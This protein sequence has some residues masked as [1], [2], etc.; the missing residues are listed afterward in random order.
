MMTALAVEWLK[1]RRTM[2]FWITTI[3]LGVGTPA[4]ATG[5]VELARSGTASGATEAKLSIIVDANA[6]GVHLSV[7]SQ[8][9]A[10]AA[11]LAAGVVIGWLFGREFTDHTVGAL[12]ALPIAKHTIAAAKLLLAVVWVCGVS[13]LATVL[14][15]VLAWIT[16]GRNMGT[17][18]DA[19]PVVAVGVMSGLLAIPLGWVAT[20]TR[21][22]L[23]AIGILIG[24]IVVTQIVTTVGAGTWFPYAI[25]SL[26]AGIAGPDA[27]ATIGLLQLSTVGLVAILGT[28]ATILSWRRLQIA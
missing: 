11:M 18:T 17:I 25:P 8:I 24:I 23:G 19:L 15:V 1:F 14:T 2:L 4:V 10:V 27:A 5:F 20:L 28:V 16:D 26:W 13:L 3:A 6:S 22:Y 12:F 9:L 7:T 21:G